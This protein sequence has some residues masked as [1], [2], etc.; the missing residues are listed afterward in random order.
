MGLLSVFLDQN[1]SPINL[2]TLS[3]LYP[4]ALPIEDT[5][6]IL[7]EW[8]ILSKLFKILNGE[9][10]KPQTFY[11]FQVGREEEIKQEIEELLTPTLAGDWN[12]QKS[13]TLD[14]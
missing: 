8:M 7:N 5:Q 11:E 4:N 13:E 10:Q 6:W 2:E 3:V 12:N 9:G 14:A 1:I